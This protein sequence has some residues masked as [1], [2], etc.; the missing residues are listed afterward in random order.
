MSFV[1]F[2]QR[3]LAHPLQLDVTFFVTNQI[4][5]HN[6]SLLWISPCAE[7]VI[8]HSDLT[9][10]KPSVCGQSPAQSDDAYL[11]ISLLQNLGQFNPG[12]HII[13]KL[14]CH[15]LQMLLIITEKTYTITKS[16]FAYPNTTNNWYNS[17]IKATTAYK[18]HPKNKKKLQW[19]STLHFCLQNTPRQ[20]TK[21]PE[22]I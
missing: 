3:S 9:L 21:H 12:L 1:F 6:I 10:L 8:V 18:T 4:S 15:L 2:L 5:L 20:H 19:A 17:M 7:M 14:L 16:L 13:S 11:N 22:K